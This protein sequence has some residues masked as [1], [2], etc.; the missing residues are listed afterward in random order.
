MALLH[1]TIAGSGIFVFTV[2]TTSRMIN[3]A[4][5]TPDLPSPSPPV[6][7]AKLLVRTDSASPSSSRQRSNSTSWNLAPSTPPKPSTLQETKENIYI[8]K[9]VPQLGTTPKSSPMP[10][11]HRRSVSLPPPVINT[12]RNSTGSASPREEVATDKQEYVPLWK[13]FLSALVHL[14]TLSPDDD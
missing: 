8:P 12:H 3:L 6:Q 2:P 11:H 7:I 14:L 9:T 13:Q 4:Q 10:S 1:S 5:S